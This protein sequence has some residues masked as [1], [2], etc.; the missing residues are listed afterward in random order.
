VPNY[1]YTCKDCH[2]SFQQHQDFADAA[3][4]VCPQCA[5]QLRKL[6]GSVGVV[7]KGAGFYRNDSR[8]KTGGS[9]GKPAVKTGGG[10]DKPATKTEATAAKAGESRKTSNSSLSTKT[11]SAG[12]ESKTGSRPAIKVSSSSAKSSAA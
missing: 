2:H 5:G 6:F 4:T 1:S 3:L 7:F 8:A 9:T 12:T 11:T 10:A